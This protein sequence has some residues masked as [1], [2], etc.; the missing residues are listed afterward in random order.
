MKPAAGKATPFSKDRPKIYSHY[1]VGGNAL[2]TKLLN[3]GG[4]VHADMA[5]ELLQHCATVEI[6]T[7]SSYAAGSPVRVN[8]KVTNVGAGHKLPT[9]FPE[10]REMWLDFKV[11]D[12]DG[13]VVYRSGAVKGG[14]TEP[15]SKT[16]KV[17]L[18]DK[19]SKIVDLELL[20]ADRILSDTRIPAKG[21]RIEDYVFIVPEGVRGPLTINADLNYWSVSPE[22]IGRLMGNKAPEI[23]IIKMANAQTKVAVAAPARLTRIQ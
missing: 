13:N 8:V 1:F 2:S 11:T 3:E 5:V 16:F 14:K 23:P 22:W 10:G 19:D 12:A 4:D 18:G 15:D 9:G 20:Q 17:T 6:S 21:Y 7:A